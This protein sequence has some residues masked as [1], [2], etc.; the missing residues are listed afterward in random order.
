[1]LRGLPK[2][3]CWLRAT[4]TIFAIALAPSTLYSLFMRPDI[5]NTPVERLIQ[6]IS[7][8]IE[9]DPK[10]ATLH[11]NL[12][13]THGMAFAKKS[14]ELEVEKRKPNEPWFGYLPPRVPY[15]EIVELNDDYRLEHKL[16]AAAMEKL[17]AAGAEHLRL[18]IES[19]RKT[20]ELDS[21]DATAE[22][23][24]AWALDQSDG[25]QE[26]VDIYR[27]LV[28]ES[29]DK[30]KDLEH[31]SLTFRSVVAEAAGYLREHL[32]AEKDK[33]EIADLE[34]KID[35]I[36]KIRRP[37]TP[38][39][40]PLA[41]TEFGSV[42]DP[43]ARVMFDADGSGR[44]LE[45]TWIRPQAGW[46]VYDNRREGKITSA[47]QMFGGVTFWCFWENG[48]Q[49]LSALDDNQDGW[50]RGPELDAL[51][52][53]QDANQNGISE[54][55]EVRPLVAFDISGIDCACEPKSIDGSVIVCNPRGCQRRD[56]TTLPTYDVVLQRAETPVANRIESNSVSQ[57]PPALGSF[58]GSAWE[59]TVFE[60]PP[61]CSWI[62]ITEQL[63]SR[64]APPKTDARLAGGVRW[65][66]Q[67]FSGFLGRAWEPGTTN[68][69]STL[70]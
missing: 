43:N 40:I 68:Q 35:K 57:S 61:R 8:Q 29:W 37:V 67:Q 52:V 3:Q 16:D 39:A 9:K 53:W 5:M 42:Y 27:K 17:Q 64:D 14:D 69:P 45:W 32:D 63:I 38:I 20:L 47:L 58:P 48:Y 36:S 2:K 55:G 65:R 60:A 12:A 56:G 33:Q 15:G 6:N 59:R 44:S 30:E 28:A 70:E 19:Y 54:L 50:L 13:R 7:K 41:G 24:L 18:S 10:N 51:A 62:P 1:M 66:S 21:A 4:I 49:A 31:A 22:L 26:A 25:D 46:L 23:G 11:L 34:S